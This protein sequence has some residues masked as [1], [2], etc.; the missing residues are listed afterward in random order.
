MPSTLGSDMLHFR[1]NESLVEVPIENRIVG[2][3]Y[4]FFSF[5]WLIPYTCLLWSILRDE[6]LRKKPTYIIVLHIGIADMLQLIFDGLF[7]GV[8]TFFGTTWGWTTNKVIGGIMNIGW[9]VYTALAHVL[10]F[11][12]YIFICKPHL[13]EKIFSKQ[14]TNLM[15]FSC[16]L[17]GLA[18]LIAYMCPDVNLVFNVYYRNWDYDQVPASRVFWLIELIQDTFHFLMSI[19]WYAF[20]FNAVR[21]K[22]GQISAQQINENKKEMKLLIQATLICIMIGLT[23]IGFFAVPEMFHEENKWTTTSSNMI[24]LAC[25]GNN[26][27]IY[28]IFNAALRRRMLDVM[29]CKKVTPPVNN[30]TLAVVRHI[31]INGVAPDIVRRG[32]SPNETTRYIA[33]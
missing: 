19:V 11:N 22:T 3:L 24:W 12:R 6:S 20:S 21:K 15:M 9:V 5:F 8:F 23:L 10:S 27:A 33:Q 18:W 31:K 16:W 30:I 14:K 25:C 1:P 32:S 4:F 2:S 17:Y 29:R 13:R 7:A 28:L 26:C